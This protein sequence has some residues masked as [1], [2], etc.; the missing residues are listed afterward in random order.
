MSCSRTPKPPS[1][2]SFRRA[3]GNKEKA[4]S[5]IYRKNV[6]G[7]VREKAMTVQPR[8]KLAAGLARQ[9]TTYHSPIISR[10]SRAQ[11]C[12]VSLTTTWSYQDRCSISHAARSMRMAI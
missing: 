6:T 11:R 10:I 2:D 9:F 5:K 4:F 12:A 8:A 3:L 7:R 1:P